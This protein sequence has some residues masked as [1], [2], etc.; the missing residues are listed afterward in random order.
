MKKIIVFSDYID[1]EE[2]VASIKMAAG[3]NHVNIDLYD[4]TEVYELGNLITPNST[5]FIDYGALSFSG[6]SGMFNHI[7][8][9][10]K[11]L[12]ENN[13][14]VTFV[15]V[16]TMGKEFYLDEIFEYSNVYTIDR[17]DSL[18]A[19]KQYLE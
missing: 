11:N 8:R 5:V 16:L 19:Y 10:L 1:H 17:E 2:D 14:S 7:E 15:Y 12:I 18:K 9:Y 3:Y 4:T 13:P 6:Q